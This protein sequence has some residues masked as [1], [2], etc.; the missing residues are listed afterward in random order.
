[1]AGDDKV[2]ITI[3]KII[4]KADAGDII[5]QK[6]LPIGPNE[7]Y[8]EIERKLDEIGPRLLTETLPLWTEGKIVPQ[9]QDDSKVTIAKLFNTE[10]GKIDWG[11]SVE[12]ISRKIRALNPNPGTFTFFDGK[13]L[14]ISRTSI[15]KKNHLLKFGEV[16]LDGNET[17][18]AAADGFVIPTSIK[19]EGKKETTASDFIHGH[20]DFVG[21]ILN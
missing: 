7:T 10:D 5:A 9:K 14:L 18:I 16:V 3:L 20:N 15:E 13:R 1:L 21:S 8:F 12:I 4:P 6:E 2:G 11:K 17:K 19:L